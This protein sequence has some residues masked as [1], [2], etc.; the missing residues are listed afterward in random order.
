MK[1]GFFT[2]IGTATKNTIIGG[3]AFG[4]VFAVVGMAIL[5]R[6]N[7]ILLGAIPGAIG[8]AVLFA[9]ARSDDEIQIPSAIQISGIIV[10]TAFAAI[11]EANGK[12]F[13]VEVIAGAITGLLLFGVG[14]VDVGD[15]GFETVGGG[16]VG[17]VAMIVLGSVPGAIVWLS[18]SLF[19]LM[20]LNTVIGM[21][22]GAILGAI[23]GFLIIYIPVRSIL[24][25]DTANEFIHE[26]EIVTLIPGTIVGAIVGT[27]SGTSIRI[28]G[29]NLSLNIAGAFGTGLGTVIVGLIVGYNIYEIVRRSE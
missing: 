11:Y 16:I 28:A 23:S 13:D 22:S 10:G 12:G 6:A 9:I 8:G 20:G 25:I 14:L 1:D 18:L 19:V 24:G 17:V 5:G 2:M 3:L 7:S 26:G 29:N 15:I 27:V 4:V 21:I